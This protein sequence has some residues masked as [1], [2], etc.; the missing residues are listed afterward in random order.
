[1]S[2]RKARRGLLEHVRF[3]GP[4]D[5]RCDEYIEHVEGC[6]DCQHEVAI[7]RALAAQ[8]R[9]ALRAR[10]E[11]FDPSPAVWR[12]VR[13]QAADPEPP[14]QWWAAATASLSRA[15][16]VMA[17]AAAVMLAAVV[18]WGGTDGQPGDS[19]ASV[20]QLARQRQWQEQ[21]RHTASVG[22]ARVERPVYR[23]TP[24]QPLPVPRGDWRYANVPLSLKI[25]SGQPTEG[26]L[27][28]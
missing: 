19:I 10:V 16:R 14:V 28:R 18:T 17:P 7:D 2:C 8:L 20:N 22:A 9:R 12:A 6:R 25:F 4:L 13:L 27:I 5:E 24:S 3:G 15:M 26:G 1:M 21:L 11:G 23:P